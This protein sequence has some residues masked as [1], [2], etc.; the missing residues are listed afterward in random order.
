M[1]DWWYCIHCKWSRWESNINF[2]FRFMFSQKW[3]CAPHYFE[4]RII[5]FGLPLYAL[6]YLWA[7]EIFPGSVCLFCCC[8]ISRPILVIYKSLKDTWMQER[9]TR[10]HSFISGNTLIGFSVQCREY[11]EQGFT[12]PPL[13]DR[14]GRSHREK[15]DWVTDMYVWVGGGRCWSRNKTT[16][17]SVS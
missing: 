4:N 2:W 8:Q 9:E 16:A 5:M 15:K 6:M 13:S 12:S 14:I 17:K 10:P 7:T 3:N 1:F 11:M